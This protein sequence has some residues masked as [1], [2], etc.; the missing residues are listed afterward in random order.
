MANIKSKDLSFNKQEPAFLRRMRE[1][2]SGLGDR[3]ERQIARPQRLRDPNADEEDAPTYVDEEGGTLSKAEYEDLLKTQSEGESGSVGGRLGAAVEPKEDVGGAVEGELQG[4][5]PKASGALRDG[6]KKQSVVNVGA[7]SKKR[8]VA[9]V[10]G[11][12]DDDDAAE[13]QHGQHPKKT[14]TTSGDGDKT[15]RAPAKKAKK[16][17]KPIKLSFGD[18]EET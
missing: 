6:S 7:P 9:K 2:N 5:D 4:T 17:G 13:V 11:G 18:D 14:T 15:K 1:A 3:H 12:G 8:K 10:V 16:K